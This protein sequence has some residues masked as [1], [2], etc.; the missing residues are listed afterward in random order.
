MKVGIIT[1]YR[2]PNYGAMLQAYALYKY[3]TH[4]GHNVEFLAHPFC[5]QRPFT[6]LRCFIS[7]HITGVRNKLANRVQY[8]I[9]DFARRL[10]LS[11]KID[12]YAQLSQLNN[13]Y[14]AVIVGSDQMWNPMW[15]SNLGCIELLFLGFLDRRVIRLSYAASFGTDQWPEDDNRALRVGELL[16]LFK[17]IGVREASGVALVEKLSRR[18]DA[19]CTVDPTLL[20]DRS[21]YEGLLTDP[22]HCKPYIFKYIL[23]WSEDD[24]AD[25]VIRALCRKHAFDVL[26]DKERVRGA[27]SIVCRMLS[28]RTKVS[29]GSWL[30][31]INGASYVV[32]NSFHGTVFSII[33][34]KAFVSLRIEGEM[35]GMNERLQTLLSRLGLADRFVS[36]SD[37]E[38]INRVVCSTID[39][40]KVDMR[41]NE[42]RMTSADF[43]AKN[44]M[45]DDSCK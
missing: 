42:W 14:D 16:Q 5:L 29:V 4:S 1:F 18:S 13:R 36:S 12:D 3:L 11:K 32:T 24:A 23:N 27:L 22:G 43:L 19:V 9:V 37:E 21:F 44:L 31:L 33:F 25:N 38:S 30:G 10:P 2:A 7:R 15:C 8:S 17:G 26:D 20:H 6:L 34:H 45:A 41:L 28:V 40:T 35:S 39:W